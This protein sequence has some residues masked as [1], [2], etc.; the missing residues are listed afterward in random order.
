MR[1]IHSSKDR[2]LIFQISFF[3]EWY[4]K[5]KT[6]NDESQAWATTTTDG[7]PVHR[8]VIHSQPLGAGTVLENLV[9]IKGASPDRKLVRQTWTF[10]YHIVCNIISTYLSCGDGAKN[11]HSCTNQIHSEHIL[12]STFNFVTIFNSRP[13]NKRLCIAVPQLI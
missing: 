7:S 2:S 1:V 10:E 13:I 5:G 6:R 8:Q 12:Q 4:H 3:P 9:I 11:P